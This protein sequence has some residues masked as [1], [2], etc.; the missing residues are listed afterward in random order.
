ME[1]GNEWL[2]SSH[3]HSGGMSVTMDG[4]IDAITQMYC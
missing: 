4:I 3:P 1:P 2:Q